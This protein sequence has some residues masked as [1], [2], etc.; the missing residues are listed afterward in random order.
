MGFVFAASILLG[1][2]S[3]KRATIFHVI[4]GT[5]LFQS[6]LVSNQPLVNKLTQSEAFKDLPEISR[7]IIQNGIILYALAQVG[8]AKK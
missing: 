2:A 6:I 4:V 5:F 1:G 3:F 7:M 8:R